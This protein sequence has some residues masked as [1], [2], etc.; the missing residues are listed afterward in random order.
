M[1][2]A[3]ALHWSRWSPALPWRKNRSRSL[4]GMPFTLQLR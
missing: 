4:Q 1:R 2:Y 3:L